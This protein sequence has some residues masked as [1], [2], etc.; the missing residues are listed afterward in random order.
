MEFKTTNRTDRRVAAFTFVEVMVAMSLGVVLLASVFAT[1]SFMGRSFTSFSNY[2]DLDRKSRA[3][4]DKLSR[5]IRKSATLLTNSTTRLDFQAT[6]GSVFSYLYNTNNGTLVRLQN[7]VSSVLLTECEYLKFG[8][9]QRNSVSNSYD[10]FTNAT[11][12]TCKVVQFEWVCSRKVVGS[13]L[14]T[15]SVQSAKVVIRSK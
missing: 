2:S 13:R 8:V 12:L 14:N 15:E 1:A 11:P 5:E 7:G 6:D 10:Q 3:A 4:L 9:Y